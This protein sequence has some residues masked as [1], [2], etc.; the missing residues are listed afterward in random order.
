VEGVAKT[1]AIKR[2]LE[3]KEIL[4]SVG[5]A[6]EDVEKPECLE[7]WADNFSTTHG[8]F[9]R[10]LSMAVNPKVRA[11]DFRVEE[12]K[13][14]PAGYNIQVWDGKN[15]LQDGLLEFLQSRG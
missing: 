2:V 10:H 3:D 5:V 15:H 4:K 9:D 11:I 13:E 8:G 6:P 12:P 14:F 7:I 1:V